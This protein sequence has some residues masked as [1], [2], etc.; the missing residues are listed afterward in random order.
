MIRHLIPGL[1]AT[2]LATT[3][4]ACG[5]DTGTNCG[6]GTVSVN[7]QCVPATDTSTSNNDS[8]TTTTTT[9]DTSTTTN[10][11]DSSTGTTAQDTAQP[12]DT[13]GACT[14]DEADKGGVGAPCTKNCQ[15]LQN[16]KGKPL[17]CYSGPIM[18]GFSFCT[19]KADGTLSEFDGVETLKYVSSCFQPAGIARFDDL[20]VKGCTTLSDCT[21]VAAAY[22]Y[23]GTPKADFDWATSSGS[24]D[25]PYW[26]TQGYVT[27]SSMVLKKTCIISTTPPYNQDYVQRP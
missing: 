18:Q 12:L 11:T 10:T 21:A 4:F 9:P 23:C 24:T 3:L 17:T 25:C 20:Y 22:D 16:L 15:C 5:D 19:R 26:S 1:I 13:S 27:G 7:G 14:P 2:C 8:A 6:A